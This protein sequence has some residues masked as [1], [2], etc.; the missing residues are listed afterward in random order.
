MSVFVLDKRHYPLRP[1]SEKRARHLLRRRK[2]IVHRRFHG[3]FGDP[4]AR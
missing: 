2:A 4:T 1:C 3:A